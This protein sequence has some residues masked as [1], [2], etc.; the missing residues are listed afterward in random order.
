[1]FKELFKKDLTCKD[2]CTIT[3]KNLCCYSCQVDKCKHQCIRFKRNKGHE[4]CSKFEKNT[5]VL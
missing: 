4:G 1:M 3:N 5:V 2:I